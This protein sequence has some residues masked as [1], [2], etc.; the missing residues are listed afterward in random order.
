MRLGRVLRQ[1]WPGGCPSSLPRFFSPVFAFN[2]R[3]CPAQATPSLEKRA[4]Q[5]TLYALPVVIMDLTRDETL[6][7]P[8]A[9]PNRFFH[10]LALSG[11]SSRAVIRPNVDTLYSNA[12]LDLTAG[13][14]ILSAPPSNGRFFM[15]QCMD[16][17][18]NVSP[19]LASAH[20]ET[21]P[22]PSQLWGPIGAEP[23]PKARRKF[24]RRR[25]WYGFWHAFTCAMMPTC[26]KHVKTAFARRIR[27][28]DFVEV[29]L[30]RSPE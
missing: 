27:P 17:W 23:S 3:V 20:S 18:T 24:A 22:R 10:Q 7:S 1:G 21:N 11:V 15:I 12:W 2:V 5:A 9:M 16:A 30:G 8:D 19:I 14:M 6:A 4:R 25:E 29:V 28:K 13:P 26:L